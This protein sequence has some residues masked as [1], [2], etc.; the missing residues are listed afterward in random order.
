MESVEAKG[1]PNMASPGRQGPSGGGSRFDREGAQVA[2]GKGRPN[3]ENP[4]RQGPSGGGSRFNSGAQ[5]A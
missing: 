4:G 3:M 1:R 2:S 5:L